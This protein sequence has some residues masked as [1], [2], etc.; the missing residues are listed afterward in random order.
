MG[1]CRG[2]GKCF[3]FLLFKFKELAFLGI[4][5]VMKFSQFQILC[6]DSTLIIKT[7]T[8]VMCMIDLLFDK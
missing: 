2:N 4:K 7:M 5:C 3:H 1:K 6:E 8:N